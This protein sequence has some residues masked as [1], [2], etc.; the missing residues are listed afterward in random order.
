M[1]REQVL[2]EVIARLPLP[3]DDDCVLVAVDGVDGAG[4]TTFADALAVA[5]TA[6]GRQ[7]ARVLL[8]DF[9]H[10]RRIRHSR[11]SDSPEGFWLDSYDYERFTQYV[12]EPLGPGGHRR[13]RPR[14]HDLDSDATLCPEQITAEAG[15]VVVVD[16]LFLHRDEL[17]HR[18][19]LSIFLD[20]PFTE[21]ARRMAH[22]DGSHADPDH[23][24]MRRYVGGQQIYLHTCEPHTRASLVIDNTDP[25]SPRIVQRA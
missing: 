25:E 20:V 13:Y 17:R 3:V 9:H 10:V 11:G 19:R 15:T 12:L 23:P 2:A 1:T 24:S 6:E 4:K 14:G 21:T 18:W 22:R 8:D 7:V 5:L 16:G